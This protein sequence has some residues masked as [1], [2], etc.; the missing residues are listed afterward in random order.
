MEKDDGWKGEGLIRNAV[1][2]KQRRSEVR[3]LTS[4]IAHNN[5]RAAGVENPAAKA[6][7]HFVK[8]A[9]YTEGKKP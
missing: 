3:R 5:R 9:V 7:G 1:T 4:T 6:H 8:A 2:V